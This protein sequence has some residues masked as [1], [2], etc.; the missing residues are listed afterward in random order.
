ADSFAVGG[1]LS[2]TFAF[3]KR[4]TVTPSYSLINWRNADAIA[5]AYIR[6][7]QPATASSV[8]NP[9]ATSSALG[10]SNA[11]SNDTIVTGSG[12]ATLARFRSRFL[13]SDLMV[14][15]E[16]K[17]ASAKYPV[18]LTFDYLENLR[19]ASSLITGT[20]QDKAYWAEINVGRT[21]EHGDLS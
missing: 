1:Q 10:S 3:G 5:Q 14:V 16:I 15:T 20:P 8:L 19:A 12:A 21:K 4:F 18:T 13:Y 6:A 11:N 2:S 17:T 7:G 9:S